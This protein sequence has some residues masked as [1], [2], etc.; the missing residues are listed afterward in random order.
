MEKIN[1]LNRKIHLQIGWFPIVIPSFSGRVW[2]LH[3][4]CSEAFNIQP[5]DCIGFFWDSNPIRK[6]RS[7]EWIGIN[8]G[9]LGHTQRFLGSTWRII[10]LSAWLVST[11]YQPFRPFG[12]GTTLLRGL[13]NHGYSPLTSPGMILQVGS[14]KTHPSVLQVILITCWSSIGTLRHGHAWQLCNFL[15]RNKKMPRRSMGLVYLATFTGKTKQ[16]IHVAKYTSPM[17]DMEYVFPQSWRNIFFSGKQKNIPPNKGSFRTHLPNPSWDG[18]LVTDVLVS[19]TIRSPE[20]TV[21][22][23]LKKYT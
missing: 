8:P 7:S 9:C 11:I 4:N 14:S 13:T 12:R 10:P 17:D 3:E 18:I 22:Q 6:E 1:S 2:N 20:K 23:K 16:N 15:L 21:T 5:P 19:H